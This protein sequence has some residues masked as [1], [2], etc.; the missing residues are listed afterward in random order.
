[1]IKIDDEKNF[2]KIL[3][4]YDIFLFDMFGV[5]WSGNQ[6]IKGTNETLEFLQKNNKIVFFLSNSPTLND[7]L[8]Q[9]FEDMGIYEN[10]HYNGIVTSGDVFNNILK[11]NNIHFKTSKDLKNCYI[12]GPISNNIL[13]NIN[14]NIVDKIEEADFVILGFPQLTLTEYNKLDKQKYKDLIFESP[15]YK[16]SYFDS[17]TIEVFM[18]KI[19]KIKKY[20]L[21]VI[22]NCA[23][24]VAMQPSK[25]DSTL[26]YVIRHGTIANKY[27]ELGGEVIETSKPYPIIYDFVFNK[28]NTELNFSKE[29]LKNKKILM[30][31]DTIDMDILG[32]T[33]A[34]K[35]L[36]I[37]VDGMLTLSGVSGRDFNKNV[38]EIEKYCIDDKLNLNYIIDSLEIIL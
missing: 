8:K 5:V 24:L 23:D 26:H 9:E 37:Q 21:P 3:L 32:A 36:G 29:E 38:N 34:T 15:M 33:N 16:E 22:N 13:K 1:M 18:D 17:L 11:N 25:N 30:V 6:K 14:Y 12:F 28:L 31:G 2:K 27:K 10:K 20:N 19:N 4:H 35:Y 7:S